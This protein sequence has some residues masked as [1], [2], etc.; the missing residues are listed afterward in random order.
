MF[1]FVR[2]SDTNNASPTLYR[3][4][5]ILIPTTLLVEIRHNSRPSPTHSDSR[6]R[7]RRKT[8]NCGSHLFI[9]RGVFLCHE[10]RCVQIFIVNVLF[11]V[12]IQQ[13]IQHRSSVSVMMT[14]NSIISKLI[15]ETIDVVRQF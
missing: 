13:I 10:I 4:R 11:Q 7:K 6:V 8:V 3:Y 5:P 12:Q 2:K 9:I 1:H 15:N 14:E